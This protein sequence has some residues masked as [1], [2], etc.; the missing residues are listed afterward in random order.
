MFRML[1]ASTPKSKAMILGLTP[2]SSSVQ[3]FR[4]CSSLS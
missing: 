2:W 3:I 1:F 4:T